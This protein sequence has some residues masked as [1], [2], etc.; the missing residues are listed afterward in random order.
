MNTKRPLI[1]ATVFVLFGCSNQEMLYEGDAGVY[2]VIPGTSNTIEYS[3][4]TTTGDYIDA[5]IKV[6]TLA[7]PQDRDRHFTL[8]VRDSSSTARPGVDYEALPQNFVM[9][10]GK[11]ETTVTVRLLCTRHLEEESVC[12]ALRIVPQ[13]DFTATIP[14]RSE[15]CLTWTNQLSKPANWDYIYKMYFGEYSRV[16]H[17]YSLA[18]LEWTPEQ[19]LEAEND[20]ERLAFG[21]IFMNTWFAENPTI[22]EN[23]KEIKPWM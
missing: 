13:G 11:T 16:K 21:G 4:L 5:E 8:A 18:I 20:V 22:D 12:L 3:F 10:A 14:S 9:P 19:L 17:R 15:V 1:F 2:F 6:Q 7:Q 23:G